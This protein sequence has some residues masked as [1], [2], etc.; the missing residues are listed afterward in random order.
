[1]DDHV[2]R[3]VRVQRPAN[4]D[5]ADVWSGIWTWSVVRPV[6]PA[7]GRPMQLRRLGYPPGWTRCHKHTKTQLYRQTPLSR[8]SADA[9]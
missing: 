2:D 1:M 4:L 3:A 5:G 9:R 7:C 8:T 6:G